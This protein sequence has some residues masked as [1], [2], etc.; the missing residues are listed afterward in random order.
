[1][2]RLALRCPVFCG[3][4]ILLLSGIAFLA[5]AEDTGARSP[6]AEAYRCLVAA[7]GDQSLSVEKRY[8]ASKMLSQAGDK[9]L[10]EILVR[11]VGDRRVFDPDYSLSST[12][13]EKSARVQTAGMQCHEILLDL[14]DGGSAI[15]YSVTDW[16][17][18]WGANKDKSYAEIVA[19]V[20][21][22]GKPSKR[23]D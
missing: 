19:M 5:H 18:W 3:C 8:I 17:A 23:R 10:L 20:N 12:G 9:E 21:A 2:D 22:V 6:L 15:E 11:H 7:L 14:I 1:M 13:E 4:G 16:D